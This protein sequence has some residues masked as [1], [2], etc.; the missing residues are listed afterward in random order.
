MDDKS[1]SRIPFTV[2]DELMIASMARWMRFIAIISVVGGLITAFLILVGI[3]YFEAVIRVQP[4][5][6]PGAGGATITV[7]AGGARAQMPADRLRHIIVENPVTF[8]AL[9]GFALILAVVGTMLGFVLYQ[10]ADDFD[11][12][13]R[14][15]V[16]DQDYI[17]AGI[18][19]VT[20]YFKFHI[21]LGVASLLV[22]IAAGIG[23]AARAS[24][25]F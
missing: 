9:G 14:S 10:A 12:V 16:A 5:A 7:T 25:G 3:I 20:T 19:Q 15:D 22:A 17:T 21:L 18:T 24:T 11:R 2:R 4:P 23:L 8:L 6:G 1:L 13:A